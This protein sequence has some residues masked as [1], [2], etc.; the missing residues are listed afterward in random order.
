MPLRQF[1]HT[2]FIDSNEE[3]HYS[4]NDLTFINEHGTEKKKIYLKYKKYLKNL[5]VKILS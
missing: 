5:K 1:I 3:K 2:A 4:L